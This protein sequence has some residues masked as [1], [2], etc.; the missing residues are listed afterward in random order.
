MVIDLILLLYF[1]MLLSSQLETCAITGVVHWGALGCVRHWKQERS[2]VHYA[3]H[4]LECGSLKS[5]F[6]DKKGLQMSMDRLVCLNLFCALRDNCQGQDL[7]EYALM[8]G[9]L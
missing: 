6:S 9:F 8:A 7:I 1:S 4:R 5:E 2:R 3:T